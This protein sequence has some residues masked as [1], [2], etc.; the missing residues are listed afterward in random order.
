MPL[1]RPPSRRPTR[2]WSDERLV[3]AC[4]AGDNHAWEALLLKYKNLIYS[5]P[6]NYGASPDDASDIFQAVCMDLMHELP[7]LRRVESLPAWIA[8]V[9]RHRSFHW[10]RG[11]VKRLTREGTDLDSAPPAVLAADEDDLVERAQHEQGVREAIDR[12]PERCQ[13]MVRMLFFEHPPRPYA[14]VAAALGLAQGSIGFIRGRCL[15]KLQR[16]LEDAG[17]S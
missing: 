15:Q 9:A 6:I 7:R 10:K 16:L 8:T 2:A 3:A 14:E 12:L 13:R 5:I 1:S 4:V 17:Y 11:A